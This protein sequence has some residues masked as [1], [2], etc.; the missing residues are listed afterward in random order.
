MLGW[1]D[2][3]CPGVGDCKKDNEGT[4]DGAS[5]PD[6]AGTSIDKDLLYHSIT[7]LFAYVAGWAIRFGSAVLNILYGGYKDVQNCDVTEIDE[8]HY[9]DFLSYVA[10]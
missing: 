9:D 4:A 3:W 10:E 6:A 7:L 1:F 8:S 2:I 5:D